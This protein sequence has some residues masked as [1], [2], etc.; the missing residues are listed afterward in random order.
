MGKT[1]NGDGRRLL[2]S[3]K[4]LLLDLQGAYEQLDTNIH[5]CGYQSSAE[6]ALALVKEFDVDW[7]DPA[8]YALVCDD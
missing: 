5:A 2:E 6:D 8:A 7:E 4:F 3:V 1:L